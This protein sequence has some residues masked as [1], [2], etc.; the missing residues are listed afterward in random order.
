MNWYIGQEIVAVI[1][2]RQ[3]AF[4]KGDEFVIQGLQ[5]SKCK[6]KYVIIDIGLQDTGDTWK[7]VAC[8]VTGTRVNSVWWFSETRFAPKQR[9]YSE[10]EIEAVNIDELTKE[11][12]LV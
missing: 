4:K 5:I 10:S 11:K 6:C 2:H 3:G 7:C 12:V 1:D 9:T 8:D